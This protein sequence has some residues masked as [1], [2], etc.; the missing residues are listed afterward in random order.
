M[1]HFV[2]NIV[3]QNITTVAGVGLE[4][5]SK[6]RVEL[7]LVLV[8]K[9]K[10]EVKIEKRIQGIESLEEL[11]K[12]IPQGIPV[13]VNFDGWGVIHKKVAIGKNG[14]P[15]VNPLPNASEEDFYIRRHNNPSGKEAFFSIVRKEQVDGVIDLMKSVGFDLLGFEMGPFSVETIFPAWDNH[16]LDIN[17]GRWLIKSEQDEIIQISSCE[18]ETE[19]NYIVGDESVEGSILPVFA[20]VVAFLLLKESWD[21]PKLQ[22]SKENFIYG[23][24]IKWTGVTLLTLFFFALLGNYFIYEDYRGKYNDLS[25][26]YELNRDVLKQLEQSEAK[27][28]K[29][30]DLLIRG[31]LAGHTCFAYYA[32][33]L[34]LLLPDRISLERMSF[35]PLRQKIKRGK[36]ADFNINRIQIEGKTHESLL[37]NQW[38]KKI[39]KEEWVKSVDIVNYGMENRGEDAFFELEIEF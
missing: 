37:L 24:L 17:T 9:R 23:R 28:R 21:H 38:V 26:I 29:N 7:S 13:A 4:L 3:Y 27:Y 34:A 31:G 10:G 22:E 6:D 20:T 18:S 2:E 39:K 30:E 5:K 33:R 16:P 35:Q 19:G 14:Q 12:Q 1:L 8:N 25:G 32:D 11:K 15:L 36:K